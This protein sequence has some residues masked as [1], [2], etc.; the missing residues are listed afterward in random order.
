MQLQSLFI[1]TP[2]KAECVISTETLKRWERMFLGGEKSVYYRGGSVP[3]LYNVYDYWTLPV[4]SL[5]PS[6]SSIL[7]YLFF[8]CFPL[9]SFD[10]ASI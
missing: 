3:T 1:T 5:S 2:L 9:T 6:L 8:Y 7:L 10:F 4:L